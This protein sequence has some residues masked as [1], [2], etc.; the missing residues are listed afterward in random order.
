[1]TIAAEASILPAL[2]EAEQAHSAH[3][4]ALVRERI[5]AA[6]EGAIGFD[7]YMRLVLYAPGLGY[8][9]AGATKLGAGGDFVTAPELS[10]LFSRCVARQCAEVLAEGGGS[11]LELGAGSGRMA[12][13]VLEALATLDALPERYLILEVSADLAARQRERLASL[14]PQL[15]GRIEWLSRLPASHRGVVLANEVLDALPC[16]RFVWRNGAAHE[17]AVGL[18][19]AGALVWRERA[20]GAALRA[21][22]EEV[23]DGLA[24]GAGLGCAWPEGFVSEI[25]HETA[26]WIS[27]IAECME[28]GAALLFDYG[29]PRA[30]YYHPER[31]QGTLRCHFRHRAHDDPFL[32]PGLQDLSAW[33]D[34]TSVAEAAVANGLGV[35]GFTTQAG[36]LLGCG[37]EALVQEANDPLERARRASEARQLLLPGEMGEVF[38]AMALTRGL[39]RPLRG[40]ALSDL[41]D[42]L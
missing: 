37:I 19:A 32:H 33:V 20:A 2:T 27:A 9:S 11:I 8:Y 38:K 17:L 6:P 13:D 23:R 35:T 18:D 3:V 29:L 5:A 22:V 25:R 12:A 24:A 16:Q 1:M 10:A 30:H 15:A 36:F 26:P 28:Q 40:F 14:A 42:S 4:A 31:S 41:L 39:D 7:E 34:F 21:A